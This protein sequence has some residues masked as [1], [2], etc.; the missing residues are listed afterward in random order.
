MLHLETRSPQVAQLASD[1][2][3]QALTVI[4]VVGRKV[5]ESL[6]WIWHPVE[7]TPLNNAEVLELFRGVGPALPRV[8]PPL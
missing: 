8:Q 3:A 7:A 1:D 6:T 4:W 5:A 2:F